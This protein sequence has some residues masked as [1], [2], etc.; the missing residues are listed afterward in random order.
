MKFKNIFKKKDSTKK[1]KEDKWSSFIKEQET[2]LEL[3]TEMEDIIKKDP[4]WT[5]FINNLPKPLKLWIST[6]YIMRNTIQTLVLVLLCVSLYLA[7]N[8]L[9]IGINFVASFFISIFIFYIYFFAK[10]RYEKQLEYTDPI[11]FFLL[12]IY[13][14]RK[15]TQVE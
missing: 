4:L 8:F 11:S 3:Q 14:E 9:W 15:K 1:I 2:Y 6:S 12:K 7:F 13:C 10:K 5:Q